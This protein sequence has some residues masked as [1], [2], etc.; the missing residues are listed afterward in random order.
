[1]VIWLRLLMKTYLSQLV[2]VI[3]LIHEKEVLWCQ[4]A[5]LCKE[6]FYFVRYGKP[7]IAIL[8]A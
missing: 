7:H 2:F 1:M 5:R 6:R 4:V 3:M 8:R